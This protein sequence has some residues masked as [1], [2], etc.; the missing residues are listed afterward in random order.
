M[1]NQRETETKKKTEPDKVIR[2]TIPSGEIREIIK[3]AKEIEVVKK[4]KINAARPLT[5]SLT[6]LQML[7]PK[8][9]I[10]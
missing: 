6:V 4:A 10:N 1:E 8:K 7:R 3:E 9:M 5:S 2:K